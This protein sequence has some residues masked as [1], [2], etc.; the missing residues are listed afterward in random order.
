MGQPIVRGA[1]AAIREAAESGEAWSGGR[2]T[3]CAHT[4][5]APKPGPD[6]PARRLANSVAGIS[7]ALKRP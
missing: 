6:V 4:R 3:R 2:S 1:G 7:P 5:Q